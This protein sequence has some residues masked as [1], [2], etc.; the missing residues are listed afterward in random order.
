MAFVHG[1]NTA[2]YYN[3]SNLSSYFNEAS[4]SQDVETAETTAF[5]DSAKTYITGLKDGT[6]SM[7]GM[8]DGNTDAVDAVLTNTLG[9]TAADVATVVPA[10]VSSSGVATFSA[11]V[12]ETSYEI[13]SPVG[14]VV[15]ANV[16][17]QATGGI[18][19]GVLLAG[20]STLSASATSSAVN[21]GSSTS[22]GGVGYLHVTANTRD[23][24]STFKVQDSAD[25]VTYADLV[26][27]T[28]VSASATGG[29]RVAVTGTVEQ[30][31]QAEVV[32]GGS[33][34]SVTY[35]MAFARK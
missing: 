7:S 27:F 1:K 15:A 30:Y 16:E 25:G 21:N 11:E 4:M 17:V 10:G 33:S 24:A 35:T 31:V 22:N 9:A 5:G 3:G 18:D 14:D 23:G 26:T 34:G 28:N 12:R 13:S 6:M 20:D 19:R 32:P 29:E 2:V 8:F